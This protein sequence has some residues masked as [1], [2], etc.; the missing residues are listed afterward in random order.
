MQDKQG[1]HIVVNNQFITILLND[2]L[3]LDYLLF[4]MAK[5]LGMIALRFETHFRYGLR[6]FLDVRLH[7]LAWKESQLE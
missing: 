4:N 3:K 6:T 1:S 5:Y 7:V 2:N